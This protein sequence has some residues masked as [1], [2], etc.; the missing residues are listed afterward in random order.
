MAVV[1][2]DTS[3]LRALDHL[4]HLDWLEELFDQV[5]L[6]PAVASESREPPAAFRPLDVN[7]YPF[8]HVLAPEN[9]AR[10]TE[11]LSV[12]DAGEAEAMALAEELPANVILIDEQTGREV[13][14]RLGFSVQGSL[15]MLVEAKRRGWCST[16]QPL[17]DRLQV[18]L[19]FFVSPALRETILRRAGE[20]PQP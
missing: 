3:P 9:A 1:V 12:L 19:R 6:P 4:G 15:G 17:L 20:L 16:I 10:V 11:L 5:Y 2:S 18:E 13:A 7:R 14:R 8:L